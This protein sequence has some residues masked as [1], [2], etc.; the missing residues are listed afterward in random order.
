MCSPPGLDTPLHVE[1]SKFNST[2]P[3]PAV[4]D[5]WG[6]PLRFP[7]HYPQAIAAFEQEPW[8]N[9]AIVLKDYGRHLHAMSV[10]AA[11]FGVPGATNAR[12]VCETRKCVNTH[13]RRKNYYHSRGTRRMDLSACHT[14]MVGQW[15]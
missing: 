2:S 12:I 5:S 3:C 6:L 13:P 7:I 9:Q 4:G 14:A 1:S 11:K 15:G 10:N 8:V